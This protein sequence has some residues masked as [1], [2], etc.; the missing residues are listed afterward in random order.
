MS[1]ANKYRELEERTTDFARRVIRLCKALPK[2]V[3]NRRLIDQII[4]SSG[5]VGANYREANESVGRRDF[6]YRLR[7]ARK[8]TKET[9]HWLD[10][11]VEANI[12]FEERAGPLYQEA[13]ELRRI[14]SA[15]ISKV[16]T[17]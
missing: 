5:S 14:L 4:R 12:D 2:D 3:I 9:E 11:I 15:I 13:Q 16:R 8:E 17:D 7:I 6:A 1:E 10:L